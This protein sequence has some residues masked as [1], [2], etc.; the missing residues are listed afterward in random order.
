M[1]NFVRHQKQPIYSLD[2]KQAKQLS[3][4]IKFSLDR[5]PSTAGVERPMQSAPRAGESADV[6]RRE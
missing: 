1:E 6:S 3:V 4:F 2:P 5:R